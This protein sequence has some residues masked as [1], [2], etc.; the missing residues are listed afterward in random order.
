MFHFCITSTPFFKL[1]KPNHLHLK[2]LTKITATMTASWVQAIENANEARA[3]PWQQH[4]IA[5]N[6]NLQGEDLLP[7]YSK[8]KISTLASRPGNFKA[9][10]GVGT[11]SFKA[12]PG[13]GTG[14]FK[15]CPGVGTG[16]FKACPGVGTGTICA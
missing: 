8:N 12:C 14:S 15:A 6:A 3:Q 5:D 13:V 11:G 16:S 9:C 2:N 4:Q 10:P 7:L 1:S